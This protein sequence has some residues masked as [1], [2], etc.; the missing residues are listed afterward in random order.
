M[1]KV[2][3][4]ENYQ[5]AWP[6]PDAPFEHHV[7]MLNGGIDIIT[8][9]LVLPEDKRFET[10]YMLLATGRGTK[11]AVEAVG[12]SGTGKTEFGNFLFGEDQRVDI[13]PDDVSDTLYGYVNPIN[14]LEKIP[15]KLKGLGGDNQNF[16]LNEVGNLANTRPLLGVWDDQRYEWAATYLTSNFPKGATFVHEHDDALKSRIAVQFLTGDHDEAGNVKIQGANA[17]RKKDLSLAPVLPGVGARQAIRDGVVERYPANISGKTANGVG[18]KTANGEYIV[19]MIRDLNSSNM[20]TP[21]SPSDARI[22]QALHDTARARMLLEK[23]AYGTEV[24]PQYIA[25]V[26]SLVLPVLVKLSSTSR[27]SFVDA[28]DRQPSNIEEAIAI[29]RLIA[30][31]AFKTLYDQEVST[32]SDRRQMTNMSVDRYSYANPEAAGVDGVGTKIDIDRILF[33]GT[34]VARQTL[35]EPQRVRPSLFKRRG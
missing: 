15:G 12:D 11:S 31:V 18:G 9:Q 1:R 32:E 28:L 7:K 27:E 25:R 35:K 21:V 22:G 6:A 16:Y 24:L 8:S 19:K 33:G 29:R 23:V 3:S 14:A 17:D 2:V 34:T 5:V 20:T 10:A 4:E 30:R 13:A 26:A